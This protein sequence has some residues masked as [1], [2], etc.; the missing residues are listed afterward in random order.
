M[1][2]EKIYYISYIVFELVFDILFYTEDLIINF[3]GI[4]PL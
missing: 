2:V 3:F 4:H 1:I